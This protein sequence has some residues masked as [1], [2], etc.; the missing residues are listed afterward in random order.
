MPVLDLLPCGHDEPPI[1]KPLDSEGIVYSWTR[2][3]TSAESNVLLAMADFLDGTLRAA[4]PVAGVDSIAIDD[5][6]VARVGTETP[7][8]FI[9]RPSDDSKD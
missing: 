1:I 5:A 4:A 8:T 2:L 3:W 6:V 7:L 9:P